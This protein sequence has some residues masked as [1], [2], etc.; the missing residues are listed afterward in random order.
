MDLC[1]NVEVFHLGETSDGKKWVSVYVTW[2]G[3][4]IIETKTRTNSHGLKPVAA[5]LAPLSSSDLNETFRRGYGG[6]PEH[7]QKFWKS[8]CPPLT[9]PGWG[10]PR[11]FRE[12]NKCH[13]FSPCGPNITKIFAHAMDA[14]LEVPLMFQ[15]DLSSP[16]GLTEMPQV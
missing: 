15:C 14:T 4:R 7:V 11:F 1:F 2:L 10:T 5:Q 6:P 16:S 12:T 8:L 9:H 13:I 3:T